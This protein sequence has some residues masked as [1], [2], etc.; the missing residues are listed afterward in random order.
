[1]I[2]IAPILLGQAI[3]FSVIH[4]NDLFRFFPSETHHFDTLKDLIFNRRVYDLA[5]GTEGEPT[6][7]PDDTIDLDEYAAA[8]AQL[9]QFT[10]IQKKARE[11]GCQTSLRKYYEASFTRYMKETFGKSPLFGPIISTVEN[12]WRLAV[13]ALGGATVIATL[14]L[15]VSTL[16]TTIMKKGEPTDQTTTETQTGPDTTVESWDY[17][18][19]TPALRGAVKGARLESWDHMGRTPGLRSAVRGARP[20]RNGDIDVASSSIVSKITGQVASFHASADAERHCGTGTFVIGRCCILNLHV[21]D[22]LTMSEKC[23]VVLPNETAKTP[24][25]WDDLI[26]HRHPEIDLALIEFPPSVR[27]F[28]DITKHFAYEADLKFNSN[29]VRIPL[30]RGRNFEILNIKAKVCTETLLVGTDPTVPEEED[31]IMEVKGYLEYRGGSTIDGDCGALVVACDPRMGRKI[32]GMHVAGQ[33]NA[34]FAFILIREHIDYL[35]AGTSMSSRLEFNPPQAAPN[36]RPTIQGAVEHLGLMTPVFE[37]TATAVRKSEIHGLFPITKAPAILRPTNGCDPLLKGAQN[38]GRTPGYVSQREMESCKESM[39]AAFFVGEPTITRTLTIEEAVFGIP[40]V[41][42]PMKTDTSPGYPWCLEKHPEPGKRH[43]IQP[44]FIHPD[45]RKAVAQLEQDALNGIVSPS[46]F[47]DT[48]KDERRKLSR[49]DPTKPEDIKTR[50]FAAS[51]MHLVIFTK[52]YFG[53]FFTHMQNER[54]ANTTAIGINPYSVEWHRIVMK[55]RE[56]N[57]RA[58]DGDYENFDTTQPPAFIDGF[59]QVARDWYKLYG[60]SNQDDRCREV[61]GRQVTFAIHLCRS[62]A[63]RVAGKNPSGTYGTTQINSG[64]N[65][66]AFQYAWDKIFPD[67][68][69]PTNFHRNVRLVTNGDDVVFSVRPAFKEFTVQNISEALAKINMKI[70]PALKEGSLVEARP[71]EECTFLKRGFKLVEGFYRG[72]LDVEVC[73]DMTQWTKKSDDNMAAT[74]ENCRIA[75]SE[76][77]LTEPSG[78]TRQK[79]SDALTRLGQHTPLPTPREVLLEH[80]KFF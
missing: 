30:K 3:P 13:G 33:I 57:N 73:K 50:V 65:L 14:G 10:D 1:M 28:K 31:D 40:G 9:P 11:L 43:W 26:I 62:E 76:L 5:F 59:L 48:L 60:G 53:A 55:L 27:D 74:I 45:L 39:K 75:A 41:I 34:G 51:P 63:Y 67:H 52:M 36:D 68:A 15:I 19:R 4:N 46:I 69:G 22:S 24:F 17:Q 18:G 66:C 47:K 80:K 25:E 6:F 61:C 72:P 35:L 78:E 54:I 49:C 12:N 56:V 42:E 2:A 20:V 44:G 23:Y 29:N 58:N 77:G 32:C 38:F 64:S 37:P 16:F 71:I 70:T 79:I 21:L 7:I 8:V